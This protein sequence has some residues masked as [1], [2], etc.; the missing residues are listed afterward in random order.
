MTQQANTSYNL[1]EVCEQLLNIPYGGLPT[2]VLETDDLELA[3]EQ[4][5]TVAEPASHKSPLDCVTFVETVLAAMFTGSTVNQIR[6]FQAPYSFLNRCHFLSCDWLVHNK[7]R[8]KLWQPGTL[9]PHKRTEAVIDKAN[10]LC[11]QPVLS[12]FAASPHFKAR[13]CAWLLAN[14]FE[15]QP[16][17]FAVD[18]LPLDIVLRHFDRLCESLPPQCIMTIVR[19]N[20][21]LT[22]RIGSFLL[23][24]H[25][26]VTFS[27]DDEVLFYHSSINAQKV[28]KTTLKAYLEF[29]QTLPQLV[30]V[31]F[32]A[33]VPEA[34]D[35]RE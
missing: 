27:L 34:L 1:M 18:Y 15:W 12:S 9:L 35:G 31:Q 19:E 32:W 8:L 21:D 5:A 17:A 20:W 10:W 28:T 24:S 29:C 33:I 6:Y 13:V 14:G 7:Q 30:G 4:L 11:K 3:L 26:G 22:E 23:M 2:L 25:L 16:K